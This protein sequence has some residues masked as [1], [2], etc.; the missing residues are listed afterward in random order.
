MKYIRCTKF[1]SVHHEEKTNNKL[2]T[3]DVRL[4][5]Q[6]IITIDLDTLY[7]LLR[8]ALMIIKIRDRWETIIIQIEYEK[9]EHAYKRI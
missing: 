7:V 8:K 9:Y 5:I 2:M 3:H 1:N 4:C 6:K